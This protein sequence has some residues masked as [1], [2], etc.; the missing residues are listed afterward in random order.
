MWERPKEDELEEFILHGG[1]TSYRELLRKVTRAWEKVHVK[2]NKPKRKDT[3][4][5]ESYTP[6]VK[7]RVRLIKLSFVIDPTYVPGIPNHITMSIEEV[8][9][10]KANIA[11]L[12]KAQAE[13]KRW[14]RASELAIWE[15]Q[16]R[17]HVIMTQIRG[18]KEA[19]AK[20]RAIAAR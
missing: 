16:E 12:K 2:D 5:E 1:E 15:H 3:S 10:L 4:S 7:E 6:W 20:S 11:R 8:D 9:R 14:K 19:L 17:E 13:G 18:F